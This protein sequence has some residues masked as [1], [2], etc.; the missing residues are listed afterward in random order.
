MRSKTQQQSSNQA[1]NFNIEPIA[2]NNETGTLRGLLDELYPGPR[3]R[4]DPPIN[5]D[6]LT[7]TLEFV[8][9]LTGRDYTSLTEVLPSNVLN[10]IKLLHVENEVSGTQLFRHLRSPR[11]GGIPTIETRIANSRDRSF[12]NGKGARRNQKASMALYRISQKGAL[13]IDTERRARIDSE[14]P[15]LGTILQSIH[16]KNVELVEPLRNAFG[17]DQE[18]YKLALSEL[19]HDIE[20]YNPVRSPRNHLLLPEILYTHLASLEFLHFAGEYRDFIETAELKSHLP[21]I[22]SEMLQFCEKLSRTHSMSIEPL[23]QI[24]S[25]ETFHTFVVS[26]A[27]D[28][29]ALVSAAISTPT[30]T[31]QLLSMNGLAAKVLLASIH[32]Q[33]DNQSPTDHQ[34]SVADCI[35]AICTIRLQQ[36]DGERMKYGPRWIGQ[37][38]R[39]TYILGQLDRLKSVESMYSEGYI[40]H[41]TLQLVVRRY[42]AVRA[43]L[44]GDTPTLTAEADFAVGTASRRRTRWRQGVAVEA[45]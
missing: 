1:T 14:I 16:A 12:P 25:V 26:H 9:E 43:S 37:A 17:I 32:H 31:T 19:T 20:A 8:G 2:Q 24:I 10:T 15:D 22:Q 6:R 4:G 36:T 33:H 18:Q 38:K 3:L 7:T 30:T 35:A 45:P 41:G 13:G 34:S 21:P 28:L 23:T 40:P 29:A 27:D 42:L 44:F 5:L 11:Q 39:S